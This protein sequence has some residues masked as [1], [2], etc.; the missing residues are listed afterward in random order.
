MYT[1][2]IIW[3]DLKH[4]FRGTPSCPEILIQLIC[5]GVLRVCVSDELPVLPL[6][7]RRPHVMQQWFGCLYT[8]L[9]GLPPGR[10]HAQHLAQCL[11]DNYSGNCAGG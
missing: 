2:A 11:T 8:G 3:K 7:L 1:I 6:P 10:N 5:A 4:R 9:C